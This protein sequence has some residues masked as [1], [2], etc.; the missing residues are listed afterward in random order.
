M[1]TKPPAGA[2]IPEPT[3]PKC[4]Y[5]KEDMP[6][7]DGYPY[8]LGMFVILSVACTKCKALLHMGIMPAARLQAAAGEEPPLIHRPS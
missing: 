8:T 1:S 3:P 6:T 5:C 2:T 4:P 7:V